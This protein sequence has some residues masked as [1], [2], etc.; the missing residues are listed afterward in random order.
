MSLKMADAIRFASG[1]SRQAFVKMKHFRVDVTQRES[2]ELIS[3]Q[4]HRLG[5]NEPMLG[6]A[7]SPVLCFQI[8][9]DGQACYLAQHGVWPLRCLP[10]RQFP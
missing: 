2:H 5:Q 8:K 7:I 9:A 4:I 3:T 10:E 6:I 1:V